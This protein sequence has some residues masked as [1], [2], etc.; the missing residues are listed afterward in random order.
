MIATPAYNQIMNVLEK[1]PTIKLERARQTAPQVFDALRDLIVSMAL[2]PGT[3][4][5]RAEL[6]EHYGI[7]QTPIRDALMRLGE[8]GLVDIFAQHATVVS[9][10]DLSAVVEAHFLRR[11]IELE[12]VRVLAEADAPTRQTLVKRLKII[13]EQQS[14]ALKSRNYIEFANTDRMFHREMYL[15]ADV[16]S[17]WDMVRQSS[18]HIDR[19]RGLHLPTK[20]KTETILKDHLA[21][22]KALNAGDAV[23]AQKTLRQHLSG[24]LSYMDEIRASHPEYVTG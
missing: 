14:Q 15:A 17:L 3:V 24:T 21:I 10:I 22:V 20:G 16:A 6:A 12:V 7:S 11:S 1:I 18:G 2:V 9:R 5:P 8:I 19:M 13:I 23:A 4:L